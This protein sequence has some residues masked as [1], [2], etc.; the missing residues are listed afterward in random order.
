[1]DRPSI[2][3]V[4]NCQVGTL[5]DLY[6]RLVPAED[7]GVVL[8]MPS[9]ESGSPEQM[10]ALEEADVVISQVLDFVPKIGEIR[11]TGAVHL[12][13][14]VAGSFLWPCTGHS[15]PL[16]A[17]HRYSDASGP[18]NA[19][20]GDSFLNRMVLEGV[21]PEEAVARF[22]AADIAS[23]RR[24]GRMRE[25]VLDKQ[26]SRD[27][28]CGY[29]FADFIDSRFRTERL[30]RSPN[31]PEIPLTL[32]L[33]S[34]VFGR[35]GVRNQIIAKMLDAPPDHVFPPTETPIHPSIISHFSL[36]CVTAETRYRYFDEGR[37]TCGEF[38]LR[39]MRYEWN[40]LLSEGFDHAA[41]GRRLEAIEVLKRALDRSPRSPAGHA[42]LG[43]LLAAQGRLA[44]AITM[45]NRA[46]ELEP[47]NSHYRQRAEHI[48][49][50]LEQAA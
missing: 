40:P 15:H 14:H 39:Y 18:Y 36:T 19:E 38:A 7:Q 32:M 30:F 12:V 16:N 28:A 6:R 47:G 22:M 8:Y 27:L 33:A 5:A 43:D 49:L 35:I 2:V 42:V 1:M 11:T 20:L 46:Q 26:R 13:P 29:T 50:Q 44:E 37:F 24:A 10:R 48:R 23:L 45:A 3:F 41:A 4:G 31:H 34:E 25:I 17:P 9:Y 21:D